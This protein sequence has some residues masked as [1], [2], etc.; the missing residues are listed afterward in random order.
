MG[1]RTLLV[2]QNAADDPIGPL[3]DWLPR[4][5]LVLD[6]RDA[7]AGDPLPAGLG[8]VRRAARARRRDGRRRR[9]SGRRGCRGVR[10][11]LAAA[12]RRRGA[13]RWACA[14]ARSCWRWRRAGGSARNPDGPEFGAQ[15]IA[16]RANCGHRPAVSRR[17][18]SRPD[19][20]QW[21]FDAVHRPAA[22]RRPAGRLAGVRGA[23]VPA[24]AAGLGHPVPHRDDAGDRPAAGPPRTRAALDGLRRRAHA[25]AQRRRPRRHRRGVAAVRR[26]LRRRSSRDPS[27]VPALA[28]A[29]H[30]HRRAGHRPGRD[31]GRAG[32]G[33]DAAR[34]PRAAEPTPAD[35]R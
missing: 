6:V 10:A 2:V 11:L 33:D 8:R 16:K 5:G 35:P 24:R 7:Q 14:S 17:C 26:G 12:V 19:V 22:E 1:D 9:R 31:P 4:A 30:R 29:A 3:G 28:P 13:R 32:R 34:Q 15:L 27:A 23:G 18:R 20:I 25:R 21:H